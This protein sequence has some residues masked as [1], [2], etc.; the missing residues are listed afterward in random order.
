MQAGFQVTE[1]VMIFLTVFT[2]LHY[3]NM[4]VLGRE[5]GGGGLAADASTKKQDIRYGV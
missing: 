4:N 1:E 5:M 3:K 2:D